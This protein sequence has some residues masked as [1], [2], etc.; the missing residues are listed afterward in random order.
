MQIFKILSMVLERL[1]SSTCYPFRTSVAPLHAPFGSISHVN[2]KIYINTNI[3][4]V[5]ALT[6]LQNKPKILHESITCR[7]HLYLL[8]ELQSWIICQS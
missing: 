8:L 3:I 1:H 7:Y 4:Y 6:Y 5:Y 2:L